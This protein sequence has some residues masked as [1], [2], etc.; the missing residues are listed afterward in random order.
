MPQAVDLAQLHT[1]VPI[2]AG[3][4]RFDNRR[5]FTWRFDASARSGSIMNRRDFLLAGA[6][7]ALA[8]A[9]SSQA[10]AN[11]TITVYQSPS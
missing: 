11:N 7:L 8:V 3:P 5:N 4:T 6:G 10:A 1:A 2:D 9:G